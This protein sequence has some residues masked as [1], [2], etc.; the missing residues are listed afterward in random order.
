M[1]PRVSVL[2]SVRDGARFLPAALES[3]RAQTFGDFELILIDDGSTDET[4][5]L[6][7]RAARDDPRVVA[8]HQA[9]LGLT[10]ALNV[11]LGRARGEIVARQDADDV[12]LP[13]R[14]AD[15]VAFLDRHPG[16]LVVGCRYLRVDERGAVLG[17]SRVPCTDLGIK[18]RL[19]RANAI[20]H[21]TAT[22]RR[23]EV[24]E[25]GGYDEGL[26]VAQDYDLWCRL[27]LRGRL[28]NLPEVGL[29][30][31]EHAAAI[32]STHAEA[33]V[34]ARDAIR[35]RYCD[36]VLGAAPGGLS[37]LLLRAAA[38]R[39]RRRSPCAS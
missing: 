32:G 4:P 25:A 34:E 30:R 35:V 5:E 16:H 19:L 11:G 20:A 12:S 10:R 31:R 37:G 33:Q 1:T 36:A 23:R 15:Q 14:L 22:F 9:N 26:T 7:D 13:H 38:S 18:I 29:R 28:A 24:L 8:I 3:V 21:S 17:R 6:V 39:R 27:A 2:C